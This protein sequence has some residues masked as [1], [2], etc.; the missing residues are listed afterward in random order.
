[1]SARLHIHLDAVGGAAGDMFVAA[2]VDAFPDLRPRVLADLAAVLPE[3]AG[4]PRLEAGLSGGIAALRFALAAPQNHDHHHHHDHGHDHHHH[5]HDHHHHGGDDAAPVRFPEIAARIAAA[6]LSPGTAAQAVAILRRLA[7]AES[8]MHRVPV[9][10]V[11]FHEIADWD[12]LMDVVAAGS[13]VAALDGATWS[14]SDLPLGGGTIRAAHGLLPVPAPATAEI[15]KSFRWRDDGVAG[16]RVT[17][18]GAAILAHLAPGPRR[19]GALRAVGCGAGSRDLPG[20]P[21]ILRALAF[22]V[23]EAPPVEADAVAVI[24]FDV[25]DMTGEEI[26]VAAERLRALAGVLD[27][28]LGARQ[29][30]KGRPLTDFRV[31]ARPEAMDA[32]SEACFRETST[33]GLRWR[34]ERRRVLARESVAGGEVRRKRCDRPGGATSKAE[35]DDLAGI[36]TLAARR[37]AARAAEEG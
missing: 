7:E 4:T 37:K 27:V 19:P 29:G 17:P 12:S 6:D 21:N 31:L 3:G 5:D 1:M 24:G 34:H 26:G 16:E 36:A 18:T 13:V 28:S 14:V 9:E 10:E 30:K 15:L 33:L 8:R 2:L 25:D 20:M 11:H 23:A 32:V 35:S 22:A